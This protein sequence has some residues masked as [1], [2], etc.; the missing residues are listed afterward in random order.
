MGITPRIEAARDG[1]RLVILNGKTYR[2]L[3][4]YRDPALDGYFFLAVAGKT[5]LKADDLAEHWLVNR[6]G[7][8]SIAYAAR[9][10]SYHLL[11]RTEWGGAPHDPRWPAV[12][13]GPLYYAF[14]GTSERAALTQ[15]RIVLEHFCPHLDLDVVA[16]SARH[17][18]D[19]CGGPRAL[20]VAA[21]VLET[22]EGE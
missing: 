13:S 6:A 8:V 14:V 2:L 3:R 17:V 19:E 7:H 4:A 1:G 16:G 20:L 12:R 22:K 5:P 9:P 11:D 15:L 18:A 21:K 10:F